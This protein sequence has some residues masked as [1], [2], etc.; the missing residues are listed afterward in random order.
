MNN[1]LQIPRTILELI[2]GWLAAPITSLDPT[3]IFLQYITFFSI[4]VLFL[5]YTIFYMIRSNGYTT[6]PKIDQKISL[7]KVTIAGPIEEIL[8]RGI[9][10]F[11]AIEAG[12]STVG[13]LFAGTM[14]WSILH[15]KH[16]DAN[17]IFLGIFFIKLFLGGY[18]WLAIII[19]SLHNIIVYMISL[20]KDSN[21]EDHPWI[22]IK[23][24]NGDKYYYM[25]DK[26]G[27]NLED[28]N[29]I[30]NEIIE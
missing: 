26:A 27:K 14:V 8:F 28:Y 22:E 3:F 25:S 30:N 16:Q 7:F 1:Y 20:F 6:L 29:N 9:P 18:W 2:F 21:L 13:A 24:I 23:D 10:M 19:H 17:T 5:I 11:I 4:G 12:V 15:H